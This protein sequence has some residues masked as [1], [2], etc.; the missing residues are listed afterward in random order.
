MVAGFS[1]IMKCFQ[2]YPGPS[3]QLGRSLAAKESAPPLFAVSR[4]ALHFA[5]A[6]VA[7]DDLQKPRPYVWFHTCSPTLGV[8]VVW[9]WRRG[10]RV[11]NITA[12]HAQNVVPR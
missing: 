6:K 2:L 8:S 7:P 5:G 3:Q 9:W 4:S 12:S 11:F 10:V 1:A